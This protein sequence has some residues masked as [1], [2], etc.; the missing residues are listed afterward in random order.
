MGITRYEAKKCNK[1]SN[2]ANKE[3]QLLTKVSSFCLLSG[4][5]KRELGTWVE[6]YYLIR[7]YVALSRTS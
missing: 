3:I 1:K 5:T 6:Q 7:H 4:P 2:N